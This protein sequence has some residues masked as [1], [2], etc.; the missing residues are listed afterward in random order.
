MGIR[1]RRRGRRVGPATGLRVR[2]PCTWMKQVSWG[3]MHPKVLP[4]HVRRRRCRLSSVC[5]TASASACLGGD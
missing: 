3:R 2:G 1:A 5:A 4:R